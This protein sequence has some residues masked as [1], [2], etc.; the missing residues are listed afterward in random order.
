MIGQTEIKACGDVFHDLLK[1]RAHEISKM[2]P[3]KLKGFI[4]IDGE[5]GKVGS[6]IRWLYTHGN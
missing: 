2:S 3:D 1:V 5:V 6:K 4:L